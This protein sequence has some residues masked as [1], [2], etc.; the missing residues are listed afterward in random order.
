VHVCLNAHN[1]RQGGPAIKHV[2]QSQPIT[3]ELLQNLDEMTNEAQL[4]LP[5]NRQNCNSLQRFFCFRECVNKSLVNFRDFVK[6]LVFS[7]TL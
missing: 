3:I 4:Y 1:K 5:T 7:G 6:S 2:V